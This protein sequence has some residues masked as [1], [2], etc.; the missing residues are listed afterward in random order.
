MTMVLSYVWQDKIVIMAD[1]RMSRYDSKGNFEHID[2]HVKIHPS[3]QLVI[4][5]SGKLLEVE[6]LIAP[7]SILTRAE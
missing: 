6:K 7:F 1:S 4:G 3:K 5:N 2:D